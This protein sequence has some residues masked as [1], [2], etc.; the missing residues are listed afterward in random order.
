M[1][2]PYFNRD[3]DEN[4]YRVDEDG[5]VVITSRFLLNPAITDE[6]IEI[7]SH[8]GHQEVTISYAFRGKHSILYDGIDDDPSISMRNPDMVKLGREKL[9]K[10]V[11]A[12]KEEI[13]T[14]DAV[15][16]ALDRTRSPFRSK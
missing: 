1:A 3:P 15:H 13:E 9:K 2:E 7:V 6:R 4:K 5:H 8:F 10:T 16:L 11:A 14:W 12:L